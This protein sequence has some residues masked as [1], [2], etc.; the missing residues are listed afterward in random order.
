MFHQLL[1]T[2]LNIFVSMPTYRKTVYKLRFNPADHSSRVPSM[3]LIS[4]KDSSACVLYAPRKPQQR[5]SSTALKHKHFPP[6]IVITSSIPRRPNLH[7]NFSRDL[8]STPN[9]PRRIQTQIRH[10]PARAQEE[11]RTRDPI[12]YIEYEA[13]EFLN[14]DSEPDDQTLVSVATRIRDHGIRSPGSGLPG[15]PASDETI[16]PGYPPYRRRRVT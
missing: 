16:T 13:A 7:R 1:R 12:A 6:T 8:G 10:Q 9:Q 4:L 11:L 3:L 14:R 2:R 5:N 15:S